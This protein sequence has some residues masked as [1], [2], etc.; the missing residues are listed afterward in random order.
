MKNRSNQNIEFNGQCAFAV[1]TGKTDVK[2]GKHFL[3]KNGKTYAFSNSI[4]KLLFKLL[5]YRIKKQPK[6]GIKNKEI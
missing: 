1:S 5:P 6:F 4:T 2:G 3:I